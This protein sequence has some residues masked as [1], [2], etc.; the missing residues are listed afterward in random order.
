MITIK[1]NFINKITTT[2]TNAIG[3]YSILQIGKQSHQIT[4]SQYPNAI[5]IVGAGTPNSPGVRTVK[6]SPTHSQVQTYLSNNREMILELF[7]T[8][9]I[10]E[11]FDFLAVIYITAVDEN[12]NNN[13]TYSIPSTKLKLDLSTL[14]NTVNTQIIASASKDFDFLPAKEKLKTVEKTLNKNLSTMVI[15]KRLLNV[16]IKVRNILQHSSGIISPE[17]LVE[18]GASSI[19]E[20]H[21][22]NTVSKTAGQKITRTAFDIENITDKL[23]DIANVLIP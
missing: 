9:L 6:Y 11:W 22:N 3:A 14:S 4:A 13:G 23:I 10:Q 5:N 2:T 21:G 16:N 20:D 15:E 18:L 12:L 7:L 19:D 8:Q 17:D 1:N